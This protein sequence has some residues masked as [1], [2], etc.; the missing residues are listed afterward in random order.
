MKSNSGTQ[1]NVRNIE[2]YTD[3]L[4]ESLH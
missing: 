2:I 1:I 4:I 3:T